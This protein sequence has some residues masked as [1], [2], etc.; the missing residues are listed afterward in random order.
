M[1]N[2]WTEFERVLS[3]D[4]DFKAEIITSE[5]RVALLLL[6]DVQII[7]DI[8]LALGGLPGDDTKLEPAF[9]N[10]KVVHGGGTSEEAQAIVQMTEYVLSIRSLQHGNRWDDLERSLEE[11]P[12]YPPHISIPPTFET[13]IFRISTIS[14]NH[15]VGLALGNALEE[16][17]A[18]GDLDS[19]DISPIT[20]ENIEEAIVFAVEPTILAYSA[21]RNVPQGSEGNHR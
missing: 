19:F 21:C 11:R 9:R 7:N 6:H 2:H 13:E 15:Q 14:I 20:T 10:A 1:N 17:G 5:V 4:T 12:T 16:G 3:R 18:A 8:T